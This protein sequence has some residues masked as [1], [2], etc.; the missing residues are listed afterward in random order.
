MIGEILEVNFYLNRETKKII[1]ALS[2]MGLKLTIPIFLIFLSSFC[3]SQQKNSIVVSSS[4]HSLEYE[5]GRP[6]FWLGDTAW[7]LF[8]RL[9]IEEIIEYLDNR[10]AKGFNVIQCVI[11]AELD[12]I[13]IPNRYGDLPLIDE[14]P[15]QL[16]EAYFKLVDSVIE[17]AQEREIYL[18][19][20]P[21]WGDKVTL[22]YSGAGPVIFNK[23]NA[24][25][26][27]RLL[28]ARYKKYN[29][30]FW[31]LGGDRPAADQEESWLEVYRSMAAGL[32]A[33]S[34]KKTLKSFHPGGY[35]WESSPMLHQEAW[36]DFNMI[37]S[38]HARL[39]VPVWDLIQKDLRLLPKK[40][41]LDAE[42]CYED[43]PI[44]PWN[45]WDPSKGY[46][47]DWEVRRQLYRSVFAGGFGVTYGHHAIWQ[48]YGPSFL[49]VNYPDRNW[50][51]AMDRPAAFQ[52]G[53]LKKLI[54]SRP[55]KNRIPNQLMILNQDSIE[56]KNFM[57][58]FTDSEKTYAM[59]YL[60]NNKFVNLNMRE[61]P[62]KNIR[63]QWF[64]PETGELVEKKVVK[65]EEKMQIH[66]PNNKNST[67]W[68][69]IIDKIN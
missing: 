28:G 59:I 2:M 30:I 44:N 39:D 52:A 68:V 62:S 69:L 23:E 36:L 26:F 43:H 13:R 15:T 5:D 46:F 4:G 38:G 63:Y 16:N 3:Y 50:Q 47:R 8:H 6:F 18:A 41:S 65:V 60:P 12:G 35:I 53:F 54:L 49:P 42:P 17:L 11:L 64:K 57:T 45:G 61:F 67:D 31:I 51:E 24:H 66:V 22:K 33:G 56:A 19:I 10:K 7:E 9:K 27:G 48:F 55:S 1:L 14:D 58:A 29:H 37:Q 34:G 40:P 21:T 20:L 25:Q 32:D